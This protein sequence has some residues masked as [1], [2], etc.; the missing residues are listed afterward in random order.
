MVLLVIACDKVAV[1]PAFA[2][3]L[4]ATLMVIMSF[5][6]PVL[7]SHTMLDHASQIHVYSRIKSEV[8][9]TQSVEADSCQGQ[10]R[11]LVSYGGWYPGVLRSFL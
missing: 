7:W 11:R 3:C 2:P 5:S 10:T 1:K 9:T 6:F 4:S 8:G